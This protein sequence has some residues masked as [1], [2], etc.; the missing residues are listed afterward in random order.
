LFELRR[1]KSDRK[2]GEN[3]GGGKYTQRTAEKN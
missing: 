2:I 1:C 3:D